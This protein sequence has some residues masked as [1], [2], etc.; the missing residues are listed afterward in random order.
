[1]KSKVKW[2]ND[3]KGFGFINYKEN[4]D[5]FVHYSAIRSEGYK[6]LTEGQEVMFNLIDTAKGYQARDVEIVKDCVNS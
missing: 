6:T 3:S 2:F 1:M 5:I 4:D